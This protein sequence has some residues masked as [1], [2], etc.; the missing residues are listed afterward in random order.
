MK[1]VCPNCGK[2]T[3]IKYLLKDELDDYESF[4]EVCEHCRSSFDLGED[5]VIKNILYK[6]FISDVAKMYD[7]TQ[8][9]K[10]DFLHSYSYLT[11]DDYDATQLYFDWLYGMRRRLERREVNTI[12]G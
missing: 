11:E 7:F 4:H 9:S 1:Y 2:E 8:I 10:E 5:W 12:A 3:E 6:S